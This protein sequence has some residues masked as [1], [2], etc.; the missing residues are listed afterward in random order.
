M[1]VTRVNSAG[2]RNAFCAKF[3]DKVEDAIISGKKRYMYNTEAIKY[4]NQRVDEAR[5]ISHDFTVTSENID[6]CMVNPYGRDIILLQKSKTF[7]RKPLLD[8]PL[9]RDNLELTD[10]Q[11][12]EG[13]TRLCECLKMAPYKIYR[14]DMDQYFI[15]NGASK[16]A[17]KLLE[18]LDKATS[19]EE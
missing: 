6:A 14:K 1:Q 3:S 16:R 7:V 2:Y 8:L 11:T 5:K 18:E 19:G 12:L 9:R 17:K 4:Y 15:T 10:L 13:I